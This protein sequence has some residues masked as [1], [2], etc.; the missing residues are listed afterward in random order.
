MPD[1]QKSLTYYKELK[2]TIIHNSLQQSILFMRKKIKSGEKKRS[3][4]VILTWFKSNR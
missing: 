2:E 1:I 3:S 4:Q